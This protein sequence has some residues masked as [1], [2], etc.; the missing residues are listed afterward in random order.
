MFPHLKKTESE[1]RQRLDR[2]SVAD[3]EQS[4]RKQRADM[5]DFLNLISHAGTAA[6]PEMRLVAG[7]NKKMH[8]GR[9]VKLY[10]PLYISNFCINRCVYCGFNAASNKDRR[11]LTISEL[12]EEAAAIR[13]FGIDSILLVSGEDPDFISLDYLRTAASELKK[14]FS[15]LAIE[16]YPLSGEGYKTLF[17][18][19]VD[20]L[21]LY[22]ETYD[23]DTYNRIHLA[24]PKADYD[25]RLKAVAEGAGAGFRVIGIGTLLGIYDWRLEAVSLAAHALWLKKH[26]WRSKIQFSFPRITPT[27]EDFNIPAPVNE[28]ELEQLV[29]AFRIAFPEAEISISTRECC[30][31]R[32]RIAVN[33]AT[34]LSAASQVIPGGYIKGNE[35]DLGQFSLNDTRSVKEM[36]LELREL[37]LDPVYKDWDRVFDH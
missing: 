37:G 25:L 2:T 22:Q 1:I 4:L 10:T 26:F 21:T 20:G 15:Y 12:L 14:M 16:I 19:G 8:F 23:R 33:A 32:N 5:N 30:E 35:Q 11:R 13:S 17:E 9:T 6:I 31:F 7:R 27:A 34:T 29:L 24:G 3:V 28:I 18:A 36:D